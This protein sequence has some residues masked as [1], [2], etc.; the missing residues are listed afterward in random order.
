M[1]ATLFA[2]PCSNVGYFMGAMLVLMD[3]SESCSFVD[4]TSDTPRHVH[5]GS[6][7]PLFLHSERSG[8]QI[9]DAMPDE[10]RSFGQ[11]WSTVNHGCKV[12]CND[13]RYLVV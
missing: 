11:Q 1:D 5:S 2:V 4:A 10:M 12:C 3:F 7:T 9:I 13:L 6:A 8:A